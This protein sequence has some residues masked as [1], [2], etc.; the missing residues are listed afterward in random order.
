MLKQ[1]PLTSCQFVFKR[2]SCQI[3]GASRVPNMH[4]DQMLPKVLQVPTQRATTSLRHHT[5]KL[6]SHLPAFLTFSLHSHILSSPRKSLFASPSNHNS[7]RLSPVLNSRA[8][9]RALAIGCSSVSLFDADHLL[10]SVPFHGSPCDNAIHLH[11]FESLHFLAF[12]SKN[13]LL[14]HM[15]FRVP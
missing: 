3:I 4:I 15:C 1:T 13:N 14:T 9:R 6:S 7:P 8:T 12:R 2:W 11:P 10:L 5:R